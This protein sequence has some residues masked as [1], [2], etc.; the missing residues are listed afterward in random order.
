MGLTINNP[1][2]DEA[3]KPTSRYRLLGRVYSMG[4]FWRLRKND[5][6]FT[7]IDLK[8]A[9]PELKNCDAEQIESHLR[10]TNLMFYKAEKV[11][12]SLAVRLTLPFAFILMVILFACSPI[13]YIISGHWGYNWL[14]LSNWLKQLGF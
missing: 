7:A 5:Y 6:Y 4:Y 9:I 1:T 14:W 8:K 2:S 12:T 3:N 11:S 13:N 10:G